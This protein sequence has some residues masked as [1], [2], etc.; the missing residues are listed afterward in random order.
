M[1]RVTTYLLLQLIFFSRTATAQSRSVGGYGHVPG[2]EQVLVPFDTATIPGQF[3]TR[4]SAELWVRNDAEQPVNLFPERCSFIGREG[5]CR[6]RIDVPGN[7]TALLDVMEMTS[8]RWPGVLLYIPQDRIGDVYFNLRIRDLSK[9]LES[10][11][12]EVPIVREAEL[13]TGRT[14]LLNVTLE[15]GFRAN[16]RVYSPDLFGAQFVVR[17]YRQSTDELLVDRAFSEMLPTDAP[18]PPLVPATFDLSAA[19]DEAALAGGDRVRVSIERTWPAGARFWPL[20]G[21]TNNL[22]QEVRFVTPQ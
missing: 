3:G 6:R 15:A 1:I 20:L 17:V 5:P 14:A 12:T 9:Q 13:R 10:A 11:G 18:F 7:T 21:I 19:L 22:T 8:D 16:L 2:F 4:W